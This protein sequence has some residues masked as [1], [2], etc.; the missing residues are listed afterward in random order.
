MFAKKVDCTLNW[1]GFT[2]GVNYCKSW[3]PMHF[4]HAF[5]G[6]VLGD[7]DDTHAFCVMFLVQI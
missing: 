3:F 4:L 2:V 5:G 6:H 1:H 7:L